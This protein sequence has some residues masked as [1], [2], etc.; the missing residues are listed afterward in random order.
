MGDRDWTLEGTVTRN[1][2]GVNRQGAPY[3]MLQVGGYSFWLEAHQFD[4]FVEGEHITVR[5]VFVRDVRGASGQFEPVH[6]ITAIERTNGVK[7][8]PRAEKM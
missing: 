5:G 2:T 8:M 3:Q 6:L 4:R 7:P 1:M